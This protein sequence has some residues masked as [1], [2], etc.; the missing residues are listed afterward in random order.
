MLQNNT[1][2]TFT[3]VRGKGRVLLIEDW[4]NPTEFDSLIFRLGEKNIEVEAA[5]MIAA[6]AYPK[7]LAHEFAAEHFSAQASLALG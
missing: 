3:H 5:A 6:A 2:S 7:L 4:E 1:A